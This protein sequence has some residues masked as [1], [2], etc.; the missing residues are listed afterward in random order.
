MPGRLPFW[1]GDGLGRPA[2][3]GQALG[4]FVRETALGNEADVVE[5]CRVG[6]LDH[7]ATTNLIQLVGEQKTAT[8]QVPSDRT[9]VVERFRDELGD[10]RLVL[11]S[12]YGQRVHAPWALAIGARLQER[13]GVDSS[14]TASDDGIIIRLPDTEN[15]PPGA[16]LFTFDVEDIEDLVTQEV[17]GSAL[18]ASRFRECAARALLLPVAIPESVHRCGSSVSGPRNCWTSPAS[19]RHSRSCSRP[20]ASACRT[21]TTCLH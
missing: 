20:C 4:Q 15:E 2:E 13:Y 1:H 18:F 3:L 19:S 12:P 10:W 6:G 5:R 14:P 7:N 8:G 11:H 21:S 9:L 16:E 17:G